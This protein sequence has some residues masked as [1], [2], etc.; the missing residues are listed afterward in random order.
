MKIFLHHSSSTLLEFSSSLLLEYSGMFS[1][2]CL[3]K[4]LLNGNSVFVRD[5]EMNQT[6]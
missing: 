1:S 4:I 2:V 5:I 6:R 3:L